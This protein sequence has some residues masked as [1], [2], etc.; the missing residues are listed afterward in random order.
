MNRWWYN[1]IVLDAFKGDLTE[2]K[3]NEKAV[4]DRVLDLRQKL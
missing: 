2:L 3:A 4:I 1:D